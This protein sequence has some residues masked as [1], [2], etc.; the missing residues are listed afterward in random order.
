MAKVR[1]SYRAGVYW[2]AHNDEGGESDPEAVAG[3]LSTLLLADLFEKD[4][5]AVARDVLRIR[6][7]DG[8]ID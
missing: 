8:L 7:R 1:A 4:P 3:F 6:K 2:I 5:D